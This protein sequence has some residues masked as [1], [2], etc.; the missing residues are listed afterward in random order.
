MPKTVLV[1]DDDWAVVQLTAMWVHAAG[2]R[3]MTAPDGASGL[4]AA[5]ALRP[6]AILLDIRM[7]DM[8]GFEVIRKL[9]ASP[10]LRPIPVIFLSANAQEAARREALASGARFFLSKPYER[11]DLAAALDSV[12]EITPAVAAPVECSHAR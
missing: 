11:K 6:D 10:E 9:K 2:H 8:D 5:A 4:A 12:L 1:I 7:P 3:A